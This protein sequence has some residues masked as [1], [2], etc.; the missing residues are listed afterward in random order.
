[1]ILI[2]SQQGGG[3]AVKGTA[4]LTE[5]NGGGQFKRTVV[6]ALDPNRYHIDIAKYFL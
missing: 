4:D 6:K 2:G 1:V 3:V 5:T